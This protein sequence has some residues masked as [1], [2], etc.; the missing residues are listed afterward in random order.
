MLRLLFFKKGPLS[1]WRPY[2]IPI[3]FGKCDF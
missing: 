2:D 3:L 1:I